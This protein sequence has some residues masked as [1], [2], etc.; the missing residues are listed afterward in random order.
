MY[1]Q[2]CTQMARSLVMKPFSTV[3]ITAAS[4]SCEN[5]VSST[6]LSSLALFVCVFF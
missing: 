4:R 2:P 6:L 5:L 3:L 1:L